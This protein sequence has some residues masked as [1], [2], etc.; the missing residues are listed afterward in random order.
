MRRLVVLAALADAGRRG[1]R[2]P[3]PRRR[4]FGTASRRGR[5]PRR[6]RSSGRARPRPGT[7]RLVVPI[8]RRCVAASAVCGRRASD[9]DLT[10]DRVTGLRARHALHVSLPP[11]RPVSAIG[12]FA[13]AP[14]ADVRDDRPVRDLGRRRRDARARTAGRRSTA[15]RSTRAWPR[16]ATTS[17][18][19][20][21][22][23]STRTASVGGAPVARTTPPRS[24]RSTGS[25][26]RYP[27]SGRCAR[28]PGSTATGT[29]TSSSTTSRG[30]STARRSTR[31]GV[32]AFRDYS[33]VTYSA[34]TG[35]Y[36]SVRWGRNLEL[37]FLD[38]RSF[39]SAKATAACG[40]DL[41]PTAPQAVRDAFATLAPALAEPGAARVPRRDQRP[42]AHDARRTPVRGVHEGDQGLDRD[43]EGRR[44]RGSDPAVLRAAVRPLG[45][46]CGRARAAPPLP[47]GERRRT[48]SSSRRTRTRTS[49]N[50]VR[51][52]T[53]G[54]PPEGSGMWE[55][56]TGPGRDEHLREG[57]RPL[58]RHSRAP[59]RRSRSLFFKPQPPN[60]LGH[61]LR[62]ARHVQLRAGDA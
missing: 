19:T 59:A 18:S 12:T 28:R 10:V 54:G 17:T 16:S 57:D 50:E 23:R 62:R 52:R 36:R 45:G 33:P 40:G 21:A 35:L 13:T 2:R 47:P 39:R 43:L 25:A 15:S 44:Q 48:S 60:G 32:E 22:T 11:G 46:L 29:T 27:R 14:R 30:P 37:F 4:R 31:A 58:P 55:V 42:V 41:A 24:G 5:S 49:I 38:E 8:E 61:A 1:G 20:S 9:D 53:L 34:A 26:S 7:S 51:F 6:R 3:T 56:V